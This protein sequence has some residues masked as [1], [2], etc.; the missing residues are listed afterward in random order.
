MPGH[1][2]N[3]A[4]IRRLGQQQK[5]QS[6]ISSKSDRED[7][8]TDLCLTGCLMVVRLVDVSGNLSLSH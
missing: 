5:S 7:S 8:V 2:L 6:D 1:T 4:R 3:G